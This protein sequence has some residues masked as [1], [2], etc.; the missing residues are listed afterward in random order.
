[1]NEPLITLRMI[2]AFRAVM[3][4][5]GI[6]RAAQLLH[7]SQPSVSRLVADLES[8][9]QLTLFERRGRRVVP[10]ADALALYAEV[11]QSFSGLDR[12]IAASGRIRER[13]QGHL[14]IACMP[15]FALSDM[16]HAI[17]AMSRQHPG[18][19][20]RIEM[21]ASGI[22]RQRVQ[23]GDADLAFA[24][25]PGDLLPFQVLR[26]YRANCACILPPGHAL[27][28][29][30]SVTPGMLAS[31]PFIAL[32]PA[33]LTGA[34]VEAGFRKAGV[35]RRRIVAETPQSVLASDLV[36]Q[37]LG[38]SVVDPYAARRHRLR[39]GLVKKFSPG[40]PF[41]MGCL[42]RSGE[43]LSA[44]AKKLLDTLDHVRKP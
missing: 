23:A 21:T 12:I 17:A 42:A 15:T 20:V 44:A 22:A 26:R 9:M 3:L 14:R 38:V 6:T 33:T 24:I 5:G 25:L 19:Y 13:R 1:M 34:E 41:E 43:G 18:V 7:V 37:G 36:M 10:T 27:K 4:G 39:G 32:S 2:E 11:E 30:K 28:D 16:A 35:Q 31:E 29:K 8:R 40:I